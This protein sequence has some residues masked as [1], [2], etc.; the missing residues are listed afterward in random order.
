[1]F[2]YFSYFCP[3]EKK[4]IR[5]NKKNHSKN[6]KKKSVKGSPDC[7]CFAIFCNCLHFLQK[8]SVAWLWLHG[9]GEPNLETKNLHFFQKFC[10]NSQFNCIFWKKKW[11]WLLG[12]GE[13]KL[14]KKCI[15]FAFVCKKR[16]PQ[17]YVLHFLQKSQWP[18]LDCMG[19]VNQNC[20]TMHLICFFFAKKSRWLGLD[21]SG[22]VN[23]KRPKKC[24]QKCK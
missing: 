16:I 20:K 14:Q 7:I 10:K 22:L 15:L 18:G 24:K 2:S 1:M 4:K 3:N 21:Y 6:T 23:R 9:F 19:L 11:P 17:L 5:K 8:K 12:F 13:P